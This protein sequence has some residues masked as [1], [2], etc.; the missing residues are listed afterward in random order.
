MSFIKIAILNASTVLKD[1]DLTTA[2]AALQR[3]V[4]EDF[5]PIWGWDADISYIPS[6]QVPPPGA[7]QIVV[8]DDSDQA[9]ALGYHDLTAEGLPIGKVF[10][11]TDLDNGMSWT[12]TL[13]HETLEMLA[14]PDINLTAEASSKLL[15]AY[16]I[17]DAVEADNLGYRINGI[18][19]S[20][21]VYPSWFE[22]FR[23]AGS[24]QFAHKTAL[25]KPF[26]LAPGGYISILKVRGG[27]WTQVYAEKTKLSITMR[28]KVGSRRERRMLDR[29]EWIKS[30]K[31]TP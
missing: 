16:E 5:A 4:R 3:Q 13:S 6:G 14:D 24:T 19:V 27:G 31:G 2:V 12:V 11:K 15:Y 29:K 28:P 22:G 18:L 7:W 10:A 25:T 9:G 17:C 8:M 26:Q 30:T 1:D 21:F 23:K 20:D